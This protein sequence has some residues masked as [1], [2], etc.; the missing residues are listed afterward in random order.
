MSFYEFLRYIQSLPAGE[1]RASLARLALNTFFDPHAYGF[2]L[3]AMLNLRPQSLAIARAVLNACAADPLQYTR[4]P[5][6][7]FEQLRAEIEDGT[8]RIP[9]VSASSEGRSHGRY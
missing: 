2:D 4:Y 9:M 3:S 5:D 6:A 7:H 1:E 8:C